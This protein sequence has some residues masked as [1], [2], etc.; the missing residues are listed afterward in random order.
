MTPC[1]CSS[2]RPCSS[3]A[4]DS[5]R[6]VASGDVSLALNLCSCSSDSSAAIMRLCGCAWRLIPSRRAASASCGS[7]SDGERASHQQW[8]SVDRSLERMQ[9]QGRGDGEGVGGLHLGAAPSLVRRG[10][11]NPELSLSRVGELSEGLCVERPVAH[12]VREATFERE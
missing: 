9:R 11:I 1:S 6:A 12:Q 3:H 7:S 10:P 4:K 2:V 8:T 5:S